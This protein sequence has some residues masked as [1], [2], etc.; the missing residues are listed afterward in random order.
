MRANR[1]AYVRS[2]WRFEVRSVPLADPGSGQLLVDVAAC[3]VCG[4]DLHIADRQ[5]SDWQP[6]GHEVAG[7]VGA[8]GAGVTR[9]K[10]GQRVALDSS[11]PC[12]K[13]ATCARRPDL[14]PTPL[15]YWGW[16]AMGF[17]QRL[18][19]PQECA[20]ALPPM[21]PFEVACLLEP[22]G[23][24]LDLVKTAGVGPGDR[25]LVL[26]PGP[27]GL[28]AVCAAR[29]AGAGR[30][31]LAGRS[32]SVARMKAGLALGADALVEVDRQPL[33]QF[34]FGEGQPDKV[35]VTA[36]PEVLPGLVGVAAFG[37]VIAYLGIAAGPKARIELDADAFHFRK[38]QLRA[39]H[40]SP[41]THGAESLRLLADCPALGRELVSHRFALED[42]AAAMETARGERETVKKMVMANPL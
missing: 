29:R 2:P 24:S 6:F 4:T 41:A 23:V 19:A 16:P 38:L 35:L 20:Y 12:G 25:V 22:V 27:L 3:G 10:V 34:D 15:T 5:A 9:F 8:V 21:M 13:C 26:G 30:V 36:P 28:G 37:G 39:S 7:V 33:G 17:G 31:W 11:A 18:L 14:C 32:R 40:A 1:S 42:V